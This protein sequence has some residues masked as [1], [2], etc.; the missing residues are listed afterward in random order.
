MP[1]PRLEP[2]PFCGGEGIPQSV[3]RDGYEQWPDDPDAR[4]HTICCR[5]CACEGGWAKSAS[6]ALRRWNMRVESGEAARLGRAIEKLD[7]A[8]QNL[9]ALRASGRQDAWIVGTNG[10]DGEP[11]K[12]TSLAA[13]LI[14]LAR[15][16][17]HPK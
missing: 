9:Y 6:G 1:E 14:A 13:A 16:G 2:C 8:A 17:E 5:Q 15:A 3:L 10:P 4:A 12:S 11:V 7:E